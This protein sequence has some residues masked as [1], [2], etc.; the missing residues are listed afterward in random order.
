MMAKKRRRRRVD[1]AKP[2]PAAGAPPP[3]TNTAAAASPAAKQ[4]KQDADE[5]ED[6]DAGIALPPMPSELGRGAVM[7]AQVRKCQHRDRFYVFLRRMLVTAV[8]VCC[9]MW[10]R[11]LS[12]APPPRPSLR[13]RVGIRLG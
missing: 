2:A 6:E 7:A 4:E 12:N 1:E 9:A 11:L 5:N 3:K 8:F 13:R 10:Q